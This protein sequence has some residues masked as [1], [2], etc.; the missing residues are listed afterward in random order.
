MLKPFSAPLTCQY[1]HIGDIPC[2]NKCRSIKSLCAIFQLLFIYQ[3]LCRFFQRT[4]F[5][6]IHQTQHTTKILKQPLTYTSPRTFS[7]FLPFKIFEERKLREQG[8]IH[9]QATTI[10]GGLMGSNSFALSKNSC[11]GLDLFLK[12]NW[13]N[14]GV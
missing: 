2:G 5:D 11:R 13:I 9:R 1:N 10:V 3:I 7:W 4:F 6:I 12:V 14:Q 8:C